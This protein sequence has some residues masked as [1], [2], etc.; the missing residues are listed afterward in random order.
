MNRKL[1]TS[2][3]PLLV[4]AAFAVMPAV[5]LAAPHW[6]SNGVL[7]KE[8][9]QVPTVSWGVL[10]FKSA[11][12]A[13]RCSIVGTGHVENEPGGGAGIDHDLMFPILCE[14]EACPSRL[15][16]HWDSAEEM[17]EA[18]EGFVRTH[19]ANPSGEILHSFADNAVTVKCYTPATEKESE[20][21]LFNVRFTGELTPKL[22]NGVSASKPSFTEFGAGSGELTSEIGPATVTGK[23]KMLGFT[24]EEVI[25]AKE[26]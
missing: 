8:A 9:K 13:A 5:A 23:L 10:T 25:T 11:G 15:L 1:V 3:A 16:V 6:Y 14:D 4:T 24:E 22:S 2:V 26:P 19:L 7:I 12:G 18:A 21:V 20:K 17:F